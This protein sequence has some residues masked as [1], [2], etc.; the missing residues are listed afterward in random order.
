[1]ARSSTNNSCFGPSDPGRADQLL[2]IMPRRVIISGRRMLDDVCGH[3]SDQVGI[4]Y[5][6]PAVTFHWPTVNESARVIRVFR[7]LQELLHP[8]DRQ[9]Q[10]KIIHVA[11]VDVDLAHELRSELSP[12][13]LEIVMEV[14]TVVAHV[15][16][17]MAVDVA[18]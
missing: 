13:F 6:L 16:T 5:R 9:V 18:V 17:D 12:V 2:L 3:D 1:M 15:I 10:I 14:V 8:V 4:V 11:A 7:V